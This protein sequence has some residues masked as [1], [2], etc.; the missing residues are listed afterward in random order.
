MI[1][2]CRG[3]LLDCYQPPE[4]EE[5]GQWP[6]ASTAAT[7]SSTAMGRCDGEPRDQPSYR[8]ERQDSTVPLFR[9]R[10]ELQGAVEP[11]IYWCED[12]R[13]A[14]SRLLGKGH[15]PKVVVRLRGV[16]LYLRFAPRSAVQTA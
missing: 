2:N 7:R 8:G 16:A 6:C 10:K 1:V 5:R 12:Q 4:K 3:Q 13:L 14:W 11:G 15:Q 9:E